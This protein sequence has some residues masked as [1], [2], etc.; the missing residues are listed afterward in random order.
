MNPNKIAEWAEKYC[1]DESPAALSP[2]VMISPI[3]WLFT[4]DNDLRLLEGW[5]MIV[6]YRSWNIRRTEKYKAELG[7]PGNQ[8]YKFADTRQQAVYDALEKAHE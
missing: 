8:W 6:N 2:G 1:P 7:E 4:G 5:R 3:D